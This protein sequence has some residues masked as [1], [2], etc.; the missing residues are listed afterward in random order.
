MTDCIRTQLAA[1][2]KNNHRQLYFTAYKIVRDAE[3]AR[4]CVASAYC[5]ALRSDSF[6][7]DSSLYTYLYTVTKNKALDHVRSHRVKHRASVAPADCE[8]VWVP[9]DIVPRAYPGPLQALLTK[10]KAQRT[11]HAL[12]KMSASKR[13]AVLL[14]VVDGWKY[15]DIAECEGVAIGTVMSRINHARA[16]LKAAV[17]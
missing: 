15:K 1:A 2:Y 9:A 14:Y 13:D 4:D 12:A 5:K 6:K 10:E 8:S 16:E 3:A 11:R 17:C 7:G